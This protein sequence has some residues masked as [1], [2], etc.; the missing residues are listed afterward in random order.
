M[1]ARA[2][3]WLRQRPATAALAAALGVMVIAAALI[4]GAE[5][6]TAAALEV[7]RAEGIEARRRTALLAVDRGLERSGAGQ[8]D[9]GLLWFSKSLENCPA[10]ARDLERVVRANL[11]A[12]AQVAP[13]LRW[14]A[15]HPDSILDVHWL[16]GHKLLTL[17]AD[18]KVRQWTLNERP[19]AR[20]VFLHASPERPVALAVS[21]DRRTAA[22]V[23]DNGTLRRWDVESGAL[24]AEPAAVNGAPPLA[25][26]P[27]GNVI[28]V[29][30][31][32][33]VR[34]FPSHGGD[35]ALAEY[36]AESIRSLAYSPD[37]RLLFAG[38]L[39]GNVY[40]WDRS[41]RHAVSDSGP[42][43]GANAAASAVTLI[44]P[45]PIVVIGSSDHVLSW[46]RGR[47]LTPLGERREHRQDISK[48]ASTRDGRLLA[49][50]SFDGVVRLWQGAHGEPAGG[51]VALDG[52]ATSVAFDETGR[53]FATGEMCSRES[54]VRVYAVPSGGAALHDLAALRG[55]IVTS[56]ALTSEGGRVLVG[57][58]KGVIREFTVPDGK[59]VGRVFAL[60]SDAARVTVSPNDE[61]VAGSTTGRIVVWRRATG[62]VVY[63]ANDAD[64]S[65]ADIAWSADS[66]TVA[67]R[68][69]RSGILAIDLE[70]GVAKPTGMNHRG[71]VAFAFDDRGARAAV[72]TWGGD[73]DLWDVH[74][75]RTVGVL[76]HPGAAEAVAF[77]A[78]RGWF[79]TVTFNGVL[80]AWKA[81]T[82]A[83]ARPQRRV[84]SPYGQLIFAR[85]AQ[86][87]LIFNAEGRA[88]VFDVETLL[89]I[90]PPAPNFFTPQMAA[91]ATRGDV[92]VTWG[93]NYQACLW[94][95]PAPARGNGTAV[96]AWVESITGRR[97][98]DDGVM[99]WLTGPEWEAARRA[100]QP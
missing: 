65:L 42:F 87:A 31:W 92:V 56:A 43:R 44:G 66:R 80:S 19:M 10:D 71:G 51:A 18:G 55:K 67:Y 30:G 90:G 48:L 70:T 81:S 83:P 75:R 61:F 74:R 94:R 58:Q 85:D 89:P 24:L 52:P 72:G 22:T 26:S 91:I 76:K 34:E 63:E 49:S 2:W 17:C 98:S 7:A 1:A 8:V 9:E 11:T 46:R 29:A 13:Q 3:R 79:H 69:S 14:I 53:F 60:G 32:K 36:A 86:R 21:D 96:A 39:A 93:R 28:A 41:T 33:S 5:R 73:M 23:S 27:D 99:R 95:M 77:D 50:A 47:E 88:C 37:G 35:D 25:F 62:K 20:E 54:A 64:S 38:V 57:D 84:P 100:S 82:G 4:A 12:W 59:L 68:P 97:L 15:P 40:A 16:H 45:E 6:R 78:R